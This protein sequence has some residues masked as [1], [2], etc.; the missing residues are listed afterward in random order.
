VKA[1]TRFGTFD[2]LLDLATEPLRPVLTR[3]RA[4]IL[5]IHPAAF[6]VVRLGE[7]SATF[8]VGPSKA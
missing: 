4:I 2:Q 5:A 3:L 7:R 6:Q 8:G 1:Q